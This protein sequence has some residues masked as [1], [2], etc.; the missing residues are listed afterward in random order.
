MTLTKE[1]HV[2]WLRSSAL[3]TSAHQQLEDELQRMKEKK[4][5]QDIIDKKDMQ[6][7]NLVEYF[8]ITDELMNLYRL[9]AMNARFETAM[10]SEMLAKQVNL[11]ELLN[12][13]PKS[14]G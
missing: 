2:T 14:H 11:K 6:I 10:L 12:Y 7:Q 9:H 13:Q 1:L 4:L 5:P 3:F 8:N